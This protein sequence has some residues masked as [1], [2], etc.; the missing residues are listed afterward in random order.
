M[1][2][3]LGAATC[4][5]T[6]SP[7]CGLKKDINNYYLVNFCCEENERERKLTLVKKVQSYRHF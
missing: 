5:N 2:F 6:A 7:V 3:E 4:G 1:G